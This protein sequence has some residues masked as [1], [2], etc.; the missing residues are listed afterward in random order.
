MPINPV[1][2]RLMRPCSVRNPR[3]NVKPGSVAPLDQQ[4]GE[5]GLPRGY[6]EGLL[7]Q[8]VGQADIAVHAA[9]I[10]VDVDRQQFLRIRTAN[11]VIDPRLPGGARSAPLRVPGHDAPW[12]I[13]QA[14]LVQKFVK[15]DTKQLEPAVLATAGLAR[16]KKIALSWSMARRL[17]SRPA[18]LMPRLA[19]QAGGILTMLMTAILVFKAREAL[20]KN[21]RRTEMWLYLPKE[22]RP[23]E[24]YAQRASSTVLHETYLT[25]ARWTAGISIVMWV[26]TLLFSLA[27]K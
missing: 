6:I 22:L 16:G 4:F 27:G 18:E 24:A 8:L 3:R 23:P 11:P 17:S 1:L 9:Q 21:Y 10:E 2:F 25:F 12:A 5:G 15:T 20:T 26:L 19:F 13:G 7:A 14:G